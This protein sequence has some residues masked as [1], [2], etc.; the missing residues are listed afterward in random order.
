MRIAIT[1]NPEKP[2][3]LELVQRTIAL[4]ADRAEIVIADD[5]R[6]TAD[7]K[8]PRVALSELAADAI[9]AIG[10]DGTYLATL[11]RTN[12]PLLA[13]N[14]G[15][16]G[17]LAEVD[18]RD[19]VKYEAAIGR[20][21]RGYYFVEERMKLA[22]QAAGTSMPDA[23]NDVVI[24]SARPAR[25]GGF[26]IA[27]DGRPVGRLQ[28]D[29]VII[30][31]PTGST[32]YALSALGPIVEPGVEGIV[33]VAIAPFRAVARAMVVDPLHTITVRPHNMVNESLAVIDGQVEARVPSGA[34]VLAYR[35]PRRA[36]FIRFGATNL[37]RLRGKGILPWSE[38]LEEK[39][40]APHADV[41]PPA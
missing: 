36:R 2:A 7:P 24:H 9:V 19:A 29:G 21:L 23:T 31:T 15:T 40:D 30:A 37:S 13:V 3:A 22:V 41:P 11:Q 38:P 4:I 27:L 8:L 35:S 39:E 25:M 10:G 20:I 33:I 16:V 12:V 26:D 28:A 14:V 18:G 1:A 6:L 32:G 5:P 17:V 34:A